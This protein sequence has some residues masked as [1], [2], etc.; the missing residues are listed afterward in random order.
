[1]DA[2][3][4]KTGL[5]LPY[6]YLSGRVFIVVSALILSVLP[7]S[8]VAEQIVSFVLIGTIGLMHGATDHVLFKNYREEKKQRGIPKSFFVVYLSVLALMVAIWLI[9]PPLAISLFILA[10]CYHFGQTQLQ[11]LPFS[12]GNWQKKLLYLI[13]GALVISAIVM[14][15][16]EE[17]AQLLSSLIDVKL[18]QA[19]F[20]SRWTI[21]AILF[22][23]YLAISL[24][25][26]I[27]KTLPY[28]LIEIIE[29]LVIVLIAWYN[30][31]LLSFALFFGLWHSLRATQVQV[32][33]LAETA[34][35]RF[36]DFI[37][38]SLPFT[39]ISIFGIAILIFTATYFNLN[40]EPF[41]LILIA[42]SILTMP[43]MII[44]EKFYGFHDHH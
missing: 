23:A 22:G 31:L 32:D 14:I 39:V 5:S 44:Y 26:K 21:L 18:T 7:L 43:H 20:D 15:N 19:I 10:S 33:K 35:F 27:K 30:S 4:Q 12:E 42:I 16:S 2:L 17:S 13:W 9:F 11:Y 34:P 25:L 24:S 6:F 8:L 29:L 28:L 41:M 37:I 40:I 1:M 38:K 36:K 3:S